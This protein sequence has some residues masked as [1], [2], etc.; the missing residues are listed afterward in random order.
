VASVSDDWDKALADQVAATATAREV[1]ITMRTHDQA[2]VIM[3]K[4]MA[5]EVLAHKRELQ[6]MLLDGNKS[7]DIEEML[8][9]CDIKLNLLETTVKLY[10]SLGAVVQ[11]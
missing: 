9:V 3:V 1:I 7:V 8:N 4:Q 11:P 6:V 5:E 2:I 10:R